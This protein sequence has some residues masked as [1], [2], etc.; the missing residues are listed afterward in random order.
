MMM[1]A[2]RE[3]PTISALARDIGA[4]RTTMT[5]NLEQ[6]EK[7]GFIYIT[8]GKDLRT[9]AVQVAPKAT[10]RSNAR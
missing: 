7:K 9:Q 1:I 10:Q 4:D 8:Q 5:R 3:N 6:L 2:R